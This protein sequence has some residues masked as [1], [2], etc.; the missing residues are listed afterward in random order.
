MFVPP[1]PPNTCQESAIFFYHFLFQFPSILWLAKVPSASAFDFRICI[2]GSG[3]TLLSLSNYINCFHIGP[4]QKD[5]GPHQS[6]SYQPLGS[7]CR[8]LT[9]ITA[10]S[11]FL[12]NSVLLA[13]GFERT[14]HQQVWGLFLLA[15]RTSGHQRL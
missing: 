8:G 12:K 7:Q 1:P 14:N 10:D 6:H 4:I 13:S 15:H 9:P 2:M 3:P 5:K 11:S